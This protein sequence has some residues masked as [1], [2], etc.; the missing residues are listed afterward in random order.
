MERKHIRLSTKLAMAAAGL[1]IGGSTALGVGVYR[2]EQNAQEKDTAGQWMAGA[3]AISILYAYILAETARS[4][5]SA[6]KFDR[7]LEEKPRRHKSQNN[8]F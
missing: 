5:A 8:S 1:F 3:G 4:Q 7:W 6:E 2:V